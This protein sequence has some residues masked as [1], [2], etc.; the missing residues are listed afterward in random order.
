MV[1]L[2]PACLRHLT[3]PRTEPGSNWIGSPGQLPRPA[4]KRLFRSS[5]RLADWEVK[6]EPPVNSVLP[7]GRQYIEGLR[8][9]VG[10]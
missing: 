8:K 10:L 9:L 5:K 1:E 3:I 7:V 4:R 6:L 2:K